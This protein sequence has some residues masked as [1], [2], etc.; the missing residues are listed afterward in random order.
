MVR[1]VLANAG[2]V[3]DPGSIPGWGRSPGGG[4]QQPSPVFLTGESRGQ[5]SLE[6][7]SPRGC[8]K[9]DTNEHACICIC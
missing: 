1:N 9:S 5:K 4:N 7:Y 2:D 6:G 3:R 8:K